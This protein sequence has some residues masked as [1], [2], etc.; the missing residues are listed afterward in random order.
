MGRRRLRMPDASPS[1]WTPLAGSS[2]SRRSR[3]FAAS[4]RIRSG[5]P[6][7][8]SASTRCTWSMQAARIA[9]R[10][11]MRRRRP[12]RAAVRRACA[13]F[14]QGRHHRTARAQTAACAGPRTVTKPP[15]VRWRARFSSGSASRAAIVDQVV[16]LVENHLA[17]SSIGTDVTP[18]AVRRL[19]MRLAPA[20]ITQLVRLIEADA[21]R[22]PS[23]SRRGLPDSAARIRDMAAA[24]AVADEAA[25]AADPRPPRAAVFQGS[26]RESTSAK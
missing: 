14:R 8:T 12:R 25:A 10:D 16:P 17:H 5:I 21:F 15:A 22:P 9:E 4:R 13:R 24:Q 6:K 7:A 26:T 18:R 11:G 1:I 20:S 3:I 23:A 2:T 19:A